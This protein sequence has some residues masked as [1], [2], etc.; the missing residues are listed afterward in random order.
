MLH[1]RIDRPELLDEG[2]APGVEIR[3]SLDDLRRL[4]TLVFGVS[5]TLTP[6]KRWL[7][8]SPK[9][10]SV[11]DVGTG[12]GQMA[13]VVARWAAREY[14]AVHIYALDLVP[15]HLRHAQAW[16]RWFATPQ[17]K[18][19]AG[20]ALELPLADQSVDYV[21]SS[22]FLHHFDEPALLRLFAECRRVAR[23]GIVMSDLWRHPLPFY[24]YKLLLEPLLVRSPVTRADSTASFHR[25]YRPG[26]I[27]RIATATLPN[28]SV[29]L[30]FPAFRW[31]LTSRWDGRGNQEAGAAGA[32]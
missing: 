17:V 21:T 18:L 20:S 11:L 4:N 10:T 1:N 22:L 31:L 6:L 5:V 12:S 26:E 24:L 19:L 3:R 23:R 8:E 30:H 9:P 2:R 32:T 16:S 13:Q 7:R 28:V 14:Q 15:R 27:R 29:S 25:S